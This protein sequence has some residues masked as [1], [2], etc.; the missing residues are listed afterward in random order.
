M[1]AAIGA[2]AALLSALVTWLFTAW[3]K[4]TKKIEDPQYQHEQRTAQDDAAIARGADGV[5]DLNRRLADYDVRLPD[6]GGPRD[7]V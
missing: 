4:R 5:D 3:V 2:I 7:P 1:I 6:S